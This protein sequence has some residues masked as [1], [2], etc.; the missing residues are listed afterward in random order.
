MNG[1][2]YQRLPG[3]SNQLVSLF[4]D[5]HGNG[6]RRADQFASGPQSTAPTCIAV[7]HGWR[8]C[9]MQIDISAEGVRPFCGFQPQRWDQGQFTD[10]DL[11]R[12]YR[13]K[14]HEGHKENFYCCIRESGLP[15]SHVFSHVQTM[16]TCHLCA[17]GCPAG[18]QNS[19][20]P[21]GGKNRW[22]RSGSQLLRPH[23]ASRVRDSLFMKRACRNHDSYES[24]ESCFGKNL[25]S[26]RQGRPILS[27]R[28]IACFLKLPLEG[29][30]GPPDP[31]SLLQ[32]TAEM[33]LVVDLLQTVALVPVGDHHL[34]K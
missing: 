22:R 29:F 25:A 10:E 8:H 6:C 26:G 32:T 12:F 30:D 16:N 7:S 15:V 17:I 13:G 24:R 27:R 19:L 21:Q 23:P 33:T 2:F 28:I 20:G 18:S 5:T 34:T 4:T 11:R 1:P 14:P 3:D 9:P 31:A